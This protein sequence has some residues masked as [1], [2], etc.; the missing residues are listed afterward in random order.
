MEKDFSLCRDLSQCRW[1]SEIDKKI[2]K[3][4]HLAN[5]RIKKKKKICKK[6][7]HDKQDF[8]RHFS[9]EK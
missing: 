3:D 8:S 5:F 4:G 9:N 7:C 6:K 2:E 1:K